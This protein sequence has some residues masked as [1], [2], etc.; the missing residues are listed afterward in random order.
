MVRVVTVAEAA[1]RWHQAGVSTIP[2]LKGGT[3]RPVV[4]WAEYQARIPTLGELDRWWGNGHEYGLAIICGAI[5]GNLE[6]VEL[7]AR[8]NTGE[9]MLGLDAAMREAGI[10]D[11]WAALT[12]ERFA[13]LEVSP[14]GGLHILYRILDHPVPGNTKIANDEDRH[15]LAETRGEGGYVIVAPTSGLCHPSGHPWELAIGDYGEVPNITWEQREALHKVLRDTLDRTPKLPALPETTSP[16]LP[17]TTAGRAGVTPGDDFE[18]S[19]DWSEILEP[20]GWTLESRRGPERHWTRPGKDRREGASATTGYKG[21][22]DRLYVFST[23]TEFDSEVPYT[24]FGAYALLNHRGNHSEAARELARQGFGERTNF[25]VST[26]DV[27][28]VDEAVVDDADVNS[29]RT[30]TH[31]EVGNVQQLWDR[32]KDRFFYFAEA[33]S[34]F[35][36]EGRIWED[37][38]SGA[39]VREMMSMTD[40][41][42]ARGQA[43]GDEGLLKWASRSRSEARIMAAVRMMKSIPGATKRASDLDPHPFLLNTDNCVLDLRTRETFDHDPKYLM[44]RITAAP[45]DPN[46]TCPKFTAFIEQVLPDPV[47]RAYVQRAVGYTMVG[48]PDKRAIFMAHGP[49]HTGKSTFMNIMGTIFG[50]YATTAPSGTLKSPRNGEK[51]PSNDLHMLR[52]KRFVSTSETND[53]ATF[54]EDLIKRLTGNDKVVSR[55]LYREHIEWTPECSIWLATNF[56]P[57]FNSDDNAIWTRAK[58]IPFTTQISEDEAISNLAEVICKEEA[59]GVLNWILDGV[60]A[61]LEDGL[62]EPEEI[63]AAATTHRETSDSVVRFLEDRISEGVLVLDPTG[64]IS[65]RELQVIYAEW[66]REVGERAFGSR[67]FRD[68]LSFSGRGLTLTPTTINGIRRSAHA[69]VKGTFMMPELE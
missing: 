65:S 48:Q 54:D 16:L 8:A 18:A 34:Y 24:K 35:T 51:G 15:V 53:S 2:I 63:R 20:H 37:D 44:T 11:L 14:S 64:S 62:A 59:A 12:G 29:S 49:T 56:P 21:D 47:M 60:T 42:L 40:S 55:A 57:R 9:T 45:Y 1:L 36:W 30:Y 28:I 5:S 58:L 22:R 67:R 52:G 33:K 17:S 46:Q 32:A 4:Q 38:Y 68:R 41:M 43:T 25:D 3:K 69:S 39:L 31:D 19:T 26:T 13:Y 23:S 7:E 66:A 6:M 10:E 27:A 50:S 61:Y